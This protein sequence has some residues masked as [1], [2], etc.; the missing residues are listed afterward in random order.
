MSSERLDSIVALLRAA[1]SAKAREGMAKFEIPPDNACGVN[2]PVLRKMARELGR[3]HDLSL[4][5]WHSGILEARILAT[6]IADPARITK[7]QME[8]WV[9]TIDSWPVCDACMFLFDKTPFAYEKAHEWSRR[10]REFE[11]RA[12]FALMAALASHDKAAPDARFVEFLPLIERA[13]DDGRNFVR[14]A[15]NWALRGIGKRNTRLNRAAIACA[16]RI[17]AID[18]RAARWIAADA[19]RE[20]QSEA[21]Q[22]RLAK[23]QPVL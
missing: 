16:K 10:K 5:L 9:R 1:G 19:L 21:V 11:K 2:T 12:A 18:S 22:A 3:D 20:L 4:Q 7:R 17:R 15:V 6:F 8:A 13:A 23:R 14:K